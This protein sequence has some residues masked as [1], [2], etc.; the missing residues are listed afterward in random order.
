MFKLLYDTLCCFF[1]HH[2]FSSWIEIHQKDG[3]YDEEH[4]FERRCKRC[5]KVEEASSW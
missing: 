5:S 3:Y 4:W 1:G 2:I